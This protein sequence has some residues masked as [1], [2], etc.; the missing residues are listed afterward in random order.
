MSEVV[1][2]GKGKSKTKIVKTVAELEKELADFIKAEEE[3]HA[4]VVATKKDIRIR[5]VADEEE[6]KKKYGDVAKKLTNGMTVEEFEAFIKRSL[7]REAIE[8]PKAKPP[9]PMVGDNKNDTD[10]ED[11]V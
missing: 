3:A 10:Q 4:N 7:E 6:E 9:F 2:G 5:K 1:T 8:N 11:G